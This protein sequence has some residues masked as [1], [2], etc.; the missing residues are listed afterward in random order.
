MS[1]GHA[2][3]DH[4][5]Q[6]YIRELITPEGVDL[7]VTLADLGARAGAFI[8]DIFIMILTLIVMTWAIATLAVDGAGDIAVVIW[9]LFFFFLRSFYFMFF[10]MGP[11]AATPGK[12]ICK[13]RVAARGKARLTANAVFARNALRELEFFLPLSYLGANAGSV[14]GWISIFGLTWGLVFLLFPIFNRDRLRA[15][16]LIAGTWVVTAPRPMLAE[17]LAGQTNA[18]AAQQFAFMPEQIEAYGVHELHVL[19][20]VIRREE[21]ETLKDVARRIRKK[22]KWEK[23]IGEKD[24]DFLK[25]YYAALRGRLETQLLFG[26]RRKDKYDK[27]KR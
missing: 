25:A 19:E 6:K 24:L 5:R 12:R 2:Y 18:A 21:A 9:V 13:I 22:I 3:Y 11:K 10:E 4:H 26:V 7:Q 27:R 17:D 23:T 16:D 15:G 1:S 14:D 8:I 20:D